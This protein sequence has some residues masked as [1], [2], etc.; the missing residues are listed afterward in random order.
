M[1]DARHCRRH[2]TTL[3]FPCAQRRLIFFRDAL[4][5]IRH[6]VALFIAYAISL[7]SD[8]RVRNDVY[9]P[10]F[11]LP[12]PPPPFLPPSSYSEAMRTRHATWMERGTFSARL[13]KFRRQGLACKFEAF[14]AITGFTFLHPQAPF[15]LS[16]SIFQSL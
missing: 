15:P 3:F 16:P 12:P 4:H 9:Y 13:E 10:L 14:E 6:F 11:P 5:C 2:V 8:F 1:R 7:F